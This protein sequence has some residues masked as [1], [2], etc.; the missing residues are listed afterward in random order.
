[1]EAN[2]EM[3]KLGKRSRITNVS[4]TKRIQ[5][6]EER[7]SSVE[8][9]VEEID[10]TVKEN[11][12]HKNLLNQTIQGIQDTIKI[13]NLVIIEIEENEDY[14]LKG[15]ENLFKKNHRRK[16]PQPKAK[17]CYKGTGSL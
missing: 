8:D 7:F 10:T 14:Q 15:P 13:P 17:D 3:E 1:M 9:T 4:I 12:K 16:L 5:E 11:S 2:L 6:I